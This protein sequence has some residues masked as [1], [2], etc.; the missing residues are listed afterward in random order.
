MAKLSMSPMIL[1]PGMFY[2]LIMQPAFADI[3]PDFNGTYNGLLSEFTVMP[4]VHLSLGQN[5]IDITRNQ[6]ILQRKDRSCNTNWKTIADSGARKIFVQELYG[7]TKNCQEEFYAGCMK[8]FRTQAPRFQQMIVDIFR[9][10]IGTDVMTNSY[11]GDVARADD[12]AGKLSWNKFDGIFTK[13][14]NY[15]TDG[16][17]PASQILAPLPS[18]EMTP[19]QAYDNLLAMEL[20]QTDEMNEQ[21]D[22]DKAYY[23][24][25]KWAYQYA[26]YLEMTGVNTVKGV[27][28]IQ[29]GIPV[30]NFHGIPVFVER[31]W[32]RVLKA[33]NA[34]NIAHAGVLTLRKN[35]VFG[36]NDEYGGGAML[37]QAL[38]VWWSDDMEEWRQKAYLTGGTELIAPKQVIFGI[39][40]IA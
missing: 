23:I 32:N 3:A 26:R 25:Y 34:G 5:L 10:A 18:G 16:T 30:L 6:N 38:R 19:T 7:A 40:N 22:L 20:A 33:L 36:T 1:T 12:A 2:E 4:K 21:E 24:D 31:G 14:A 15:A 37:N 9:K 35:F 29:N 39:T 11:F 8:D 17:I 28:Y 13:I 27:D